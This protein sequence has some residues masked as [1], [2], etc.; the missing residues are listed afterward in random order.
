MKKIEED[1]WAYIDDA[2]EPAERLEIEAKIASDPEYHR[3]HGE[4][5][6]VHLMISAEEL[7]EPSMSFTRNVME[8]VKLEIPPVALKT[9]VDN[10]IIYSIAAFFMLSILAVFI[11]A[12]ANSNYSMSA[13]KL[14]EL[15]VNLAM[16]PEATNFSVKA[17]L[18]LD[19]ALALVYFD[20][21]LRK[22]L[23]TK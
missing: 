18:F 3:L 16:S 14:P 10:R 15:N 12:L 5:M 11:Y 21:F 1:I 20:R 2:C 6:Q 22:T 8:H 9:K 4:L 17:F 19:L 7:E 23:S 13:F